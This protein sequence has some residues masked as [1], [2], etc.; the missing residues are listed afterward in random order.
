MPLALKLGINFPNDGNALSPQ[1]SQQVRSGLARNQK[2]LN[3]WIDK[4]AAIG[5]LTNRH[6]HAFARHRT[7]RLRRSPLTTA[8]PSHPVIIPSTGA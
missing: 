8:Q 3:L 1:Q 4:S 2:R 7:L 5:Q 6:A